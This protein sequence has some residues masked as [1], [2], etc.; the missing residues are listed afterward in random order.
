VSPDLRDALLQWRASL[1]GCCRFDVVF[2]DTQL[3]LKNL[4]RGVWVYLGKYRLRTIILSAKNEDPRRFREEVEKTKLDDGGYDSKTDLNRQRP[5]FMRI[6][7]LTKDAPVPFDTFHPRAYC[8]GHRLPKGNTKAI[9][10][11][12]SSPGCGGSKLSDA[13]GLAV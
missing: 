10:S 4:R 1:K 13:A 6:I 2:D 8:N 3:E 11:H 5:S 9:G 12:T 7:R